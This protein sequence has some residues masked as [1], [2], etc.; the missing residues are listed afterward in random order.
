MGGTGCV[1]RGG[2]WRRF[3]PGPGTGR[4][5]DDDDTGVDAMRGAARGVETR[6]RDRRS[7]PTVGGDDGERAANE[8]G[9]KSALALSDDILLAIGTVS[10]RR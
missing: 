3:R 2:E 7:T 4:P 5:D 6:E 10:A 9:G 8:G 1:G